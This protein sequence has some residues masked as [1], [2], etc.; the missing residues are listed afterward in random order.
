M[1]AVE[2]YSCCYT[3]IVFLIKE[4]SFPGDET[5]QILAQPSASSYHMDHQG[6]KHME[7]I[8]VPPI[9]RLICT[10]PTYIHHICK[11]TARQN[12]ENRHNYDRFDL[13]D[14]Q[15]AR[16]LLYS[17]FSLLVCLI[18]TRHTF[19]HAA[20]TPFS[21]TYILILCRSIPSIIIIII[22]G[23]KKASS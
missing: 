5:T 13:L 12:P 9:H 18:H 4:S 23:P 22:I 3:I 17:P 6:Q 19:K 14:L 16:S 2:S 11:L 10:T 21:S 7:F 8:V 15:T 1:P 20:H